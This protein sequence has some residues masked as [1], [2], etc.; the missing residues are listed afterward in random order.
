MFRP[1]L[2]KKFGGV[3]F[4]DCMVED[5]KDRPV[6]TM[7]EMDSN[8]G[9]FDLTGTITVRNLHGVRV[10]LGEKQEG[11]TLVVRESE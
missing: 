1:E 3:D 5:N 9:V 10:N 11:V 7:E 8:F 2:T 4:V 6:V